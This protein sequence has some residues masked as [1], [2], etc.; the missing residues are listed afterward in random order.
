MLEA[1]NYDVIIVGGAMTGTT[2]ALALSSKTAGKMRIAVLEKQVTH[3]HQQSGFDARCIALSDGSCQRFAQI[4]LPQSP[5]LWS[6]LQPVSTPIHKIHVSD[7]G[8]SGLLE[9][10]AQE[11]NLP[12]LGAVIELTQAGQ[13]LLNAIQ[14][15]THIDYLAPI[16]I[17]NITRNDAHVEIKLKNHRTLRGQLLV[18][19]DGTQSLVAKAANIAQKVVREYRQTAIITNILVQQ[20]H[21]YRAFE[22]FTDEGPLALLPMQD[23]L[24]SLVWCVKDAQ[25]LMTL[26]D[27]AFLS[28]LQDRFGWRLGKLLQCGQRFT[29]PLNLYQAEQHIQ[30]RIALIGNAAQTLHPIA[31]QGFNLGIRDVM[32]LADVVATHYLQQKDIGTYAHLQAYEKQR[33]SDQQQTLRLTDDLLSIFANHLLPLQFGRTLGLMTLSQSTLLRQHFAKLTLGWT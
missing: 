27:Q 24:M 17:E 7:K 15:Y 23:N 3:H 20:D 12:Q 11:F 4:Q 31:G 6:R 30:P 9:F 18:G 8:H 28:A 16:E 32:T 29:Y 25:Q 21:Q 10:R 2:L 26:N 13:I 1:A 19:A 22:R 33:Q 5:H 14:E